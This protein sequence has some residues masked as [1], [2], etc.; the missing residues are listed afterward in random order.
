[1]FKLNLINKLFL[2]KFKDS[3]FDKNNELRL[4]II[5]K[6]KA[7][8]LKDES[9]LQDLCTGHKGTLTLLCQNHLNIYFKKNFL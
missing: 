7:T 1:M 8:S 3:F 6:L 2:I 9:I 5:I 4:I